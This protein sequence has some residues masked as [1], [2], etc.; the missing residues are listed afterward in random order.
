VGFSGLERHYIEDTRM[1]AKN[2]TEER[3]VAVYRET[4]DALYA[5]VSRCCY[6]DRTLAE[7]VTQET[8]LRAVRDWRRKGPPDRPLAWLTTVARNLLASYYRRRRPA[9]LDSV[10]PGEVLAAFEDGRASRSTEIAAVV[11]HA[12]ARLPAAEAQL[13]E[14]FHF[15]EQRVAQ[16]AEGCG[17]SE[18]AV[19]GRLRRARERLRRELE[20]VMEFEGGTR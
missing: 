20:S 19:E 4:I 13:L 16:I 17:L 5:Y 3:I 9:A 2:A 15:D 10:S 7:D 12:L 1:A 8:W 18:R 14:A 11:C 6:G